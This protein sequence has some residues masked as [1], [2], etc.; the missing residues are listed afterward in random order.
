MLDIGRQAGRGARYVTLRR[1]R[2]G[3]ACVQSP[4]VLKYWSRLSAGLAED[5]QIAHA[6]HL[7][8]DRAIEVVG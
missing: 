5:S 8:P 3:R 6:I 1:C 7:W 2:C 4:E